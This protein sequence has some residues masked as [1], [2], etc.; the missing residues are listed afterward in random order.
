MTEMSRDNARKIEF[1]GSTLDECVNEL[2]EFQKRGESVF[3]DFNGHKLYSCDVTVDSAYKEVCGKTKEESDKAI[4]EYLAN[5]EKK[6][7][8]A[9]A[10]AEA[11]IPEWIKRGEGFI[12]PERAEEWK[13]C[14]EAKAA[15]DFYGKDLDEAI[16]IMEKLESGAT[17]DEAKE[18]LYSQ[19]HFAVWYRVVRNIIFEFAKR[20]PEFYEHTARGEMSADTREIIEEKKKENAELEALHRDDSTKEVPAER[21]TE[22][23]EI[24]D[25]SAEKEQLTAEISR[26]DQQLAKLRSQLQEKGPNEP[27]EPNKL[28]EK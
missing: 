7:K 16:E 21:R 1:Y 28:E 24:S 22:E 15:S 17:L 9:K 11:K 5:I 25:S 6:E 23:Q 27:N 8:E 10:K 13:K 18:L 3:I 26:T 12:Y 19:N 20:G 14:V 4:E 2:L